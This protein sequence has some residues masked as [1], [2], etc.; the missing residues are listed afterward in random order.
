MKHNK[1]LR[2]SFILSLVFALL[3]SIQLSS[4]QAQDFATKLADHFLKKIPVA[5][6]D[7]AMT[8]EQ[9]FKVQEKFV[10]IIAKEFGEPVGYKAGLTN[11]NAQ[12]AFGVTNPVRGT[13]LKKMILKSGATIEANFGARPLSEG[14]LIVRVSNEAINKAKTPEDAL[15]NLDVVIPF[16]ELPDLVYDPKLKMSGPAIFA[17]NVGARYGVM[18]EPIPLSATPEWMARLKNFTLQVYDEKGTVVTEGKGSALLGDPLAVVLW[19]KDSLAAEGKKVKEGDLLSLGTIGKM[20]PAKP[21][22][23]R[24]KYIDLDPNGPVEISVTFK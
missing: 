22:V 10:A 8:M 4:L 14:D 21:G 1:F 9:A 6:V 23:V 11:P 5:E 24:A 12:K 15:K 13:L 16:I 20:M 17:I 3:F 18:G 7:P 19:I 2:Y